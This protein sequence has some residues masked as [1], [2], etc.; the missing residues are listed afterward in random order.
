MLRGRAA[1]CLDARRKPRIKLARTSSR[2]HCRV[3]KADLQAGSRAFPFGDAPDKSGRA[4]E[5]TAG[6]GV[7]KVM[8]ALPARSAI[9]HATLED[10]IISPGATQELNMGRL[11]NASRAMSAF[12]PKI[13]TID[14]TLPL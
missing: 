5:F 4:K 1:G 6:S 9:V 10:P 3:G 2:H 14:A 12:R 8:P 7:R 13:C 11:S